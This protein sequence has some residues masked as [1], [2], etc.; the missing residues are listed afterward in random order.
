MIH[1]M[2][3]AP[4]F[5]ATCLWV[6]ENY[7]R[8]IGILT[9][10]RRCQMEVEMGISAT[11]HVCLNSAECTSQWE[12]TSHWNLKVRLFMLQDN[13]RQKV[14]SRVSSVLGGDIIPKTHTAD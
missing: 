1:A 2:S 13:V 10:P 14:G 6:S 3:K 7:S 5:K 11:V 12:T 4:S 8:S 9:P